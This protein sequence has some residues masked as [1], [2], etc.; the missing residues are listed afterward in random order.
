MLL[1]SAA[2]LQPPQACLGNAALANLPAEISGLIILAS[3]KHKLGGE[4]EEE[5]TGQGGGS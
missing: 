3:P 4:E 2:S 1:F 5:G